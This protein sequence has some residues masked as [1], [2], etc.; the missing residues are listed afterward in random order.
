M[1]TVSAGFSVS[2]DGFVADEKDDISALYGWMVGAVQQDTELDDM[3]YTDQGKDANEAR[4]AAF[5]AIVSGR[6]TFDLAKGWGGQHPLGVPVVILTH[7]VPTEWANDGKPFTFVTGGVAEAVAKAKEIA[8]DDTVAVCGPD[9]M[10]QCLEEGLLDEIGVD[11]V[12]TLL[13]K[14]VPFFAGEG[15]VQLEKVS[16]DDADGVTHLRYRVVR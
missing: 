15:P 12:P 1:S 16:A 11:L 3:E 13:G 8:G 6:R 9:V 2:L 14:G 10:R 4:S 7:E 5:G